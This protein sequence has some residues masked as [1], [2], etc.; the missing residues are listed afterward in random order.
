MIYNNSKINNSM[1]KIFTQGKGERNKKMRFCIPKLALAL[2][3]DDWKS[4]TP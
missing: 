2:G 3:K 4:K 1:P